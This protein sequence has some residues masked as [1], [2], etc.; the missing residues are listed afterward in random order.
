MS[1]L[2]FAIAYCGELTRW[3][4]IDDNFDIDEAS[5]GFLCD[6]KPLFRQLG[7]KWRGSPTETLGIVNS[8]DAIVD[9][10]VTKYAPARKCTPAG[11]A[12]RQT[13]VGRE[14][15][16]PTET[17]TV[18]EQMMPSSRASRNCSCGCRFSALSA[19]RRL[20]KKLH[21]RPGT[22]DPGNYYCS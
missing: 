10:I 20:M 7:H 1:T 17:E 19:G 9:Q 11:I 16:G 21:P 8:D 13:A 6:C 15:A 4:R 18:K 3:H 14:A 5:T 12:N 22:L 2:A